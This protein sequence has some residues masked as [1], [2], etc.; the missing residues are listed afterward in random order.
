[1]REDTDLSDILETAWSSLNIEMNQKQVQDVIGLL[2]SD[3]RMILSHPKFQSR[4][5]II[6]AINTV[7][8]RKDRPRVLKFVDGLIKRNIIQFEERLLR[9]GTAYT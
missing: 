7:V 2:K 8:Q 4:D 6:H 9:G 5:Q 1:L 3:E